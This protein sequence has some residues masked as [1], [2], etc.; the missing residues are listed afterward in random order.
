MSVPHAE[1]L[2]TVRS[3][4]VPEHKALEAATALSSPLTRVEDAADQGFSERDAD[5]EAIRRDVTALFRK[6]NI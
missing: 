2:E 6:R 5:V 1:L 3:I 4:D